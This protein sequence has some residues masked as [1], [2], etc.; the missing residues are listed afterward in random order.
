MNIIP[1]HYN[2]DF[3]SPPQIDFNDVANFDTREKIDQILCGI[4]VNTFNRFEVFLKMAEALQRYPELYW[5]ALRQAYD[6]SDGIFSKSCE[7]E[8]SFGCGLPGKENLMTNDEL[9][10]FNHLPG[11]VTIYRAMSVEEYE[12]GSFGVSWTLSKKVAEFFLTYWRCPDV[13]KGNPKT[14]AQIEVHKFSLIAYFNGRDEEEIIYM[15][16]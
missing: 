2:I 5:Y 15:H 10:F 8:L 11:Q 3:V 14:I 6:S 16:E 13:R 9:N 1:Q 7:V 12:S 4:G